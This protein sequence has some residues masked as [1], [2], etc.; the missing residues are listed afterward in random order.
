MQM[1]FGDILCTEKKKL[2]VSVGSLNNVWVIDW[3]T[4]IEETG[5]ATSQPYSHSYMQWMAKGLVP[6][7]N[8]D[9]PCRYFCWKAVMAFDIWEEEGGL[10]S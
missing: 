6:K 4:A 1:A 3:G 2:L 10:T 7:G 5:G 9:S 8:R